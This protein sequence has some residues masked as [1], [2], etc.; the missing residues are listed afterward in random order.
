MTTGINNLHSLHITHHS[1][2]I[3]H[4]AFLFL[5]LFLTAC[6]DF[7]HPVESTPEP[8]EYSYNYWL[9]QRTYLYED[10]L[11][12][13]DEN[14]DSVQELYSKLGSAI[15]EERQDIETELR[16]LEYYSDNIKKKS[17]NL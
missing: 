11:P 6:S 5:L 2:H 1:F 8:T 7:F 3:T 17:A 16:K 4:L 10:E 12:Q 13:L 9:L 15:G 14:G